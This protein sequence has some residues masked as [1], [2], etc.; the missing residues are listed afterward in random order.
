[1]EKRPDM[2]A[3]QITVTMNVKEAVFVF[4]RVTPV[5][6]AQYEISGSEAAEVQMIQMPLDMARQMVKLIEN[7]LVQVKLTEEGH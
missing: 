6:N 5:Y 1:M 2:Y 7:G 3:N 4:R